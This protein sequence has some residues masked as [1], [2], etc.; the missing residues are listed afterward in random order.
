[1]PVAQLYATI[2]NAENTEHLHAALSDI[3]DSGLPGG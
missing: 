3:R 2:W 1:M